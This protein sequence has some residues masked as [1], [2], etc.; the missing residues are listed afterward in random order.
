M[1]EETDRNEAGEIA[2]STVDEQAPSVSEEHAPSTEEPVATDLPTANAPDPTAVNPETNPNAAEEKAA[3]PKAG[4]KKPP[5]AEAE[6]GADSDEKAGDKKPAAKKEKAPALE[7]K[8][9]AEFIQQDYL[10]ALTAGLTKQGVKDLQLSFE[11]Q[12]IPVIGYAQEPECWQIIGNWDKGLRQFRVYF[13]KDDIQGQRAFSF[14]ENGGKP[15][16][17][18]PFLIDERKITLDL[19]VFGVVQRLNA[20]KWLVRN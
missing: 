19:M 13:I 6:E 3:K 8:P 17:L 9:F 16:T 18:E 11:T 12:K 2:P 10:P 20:Q 4:A 7:D 5:K 1:A 15:S 14:A